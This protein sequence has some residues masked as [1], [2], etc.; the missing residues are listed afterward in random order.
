MFRVFP[1]LLPHSYSVISQVFRVMRAVQG[2][3]HVLGDDPFRFLA[4]LRKRSIAGYPF[5]IA[6]VPTPR[7]SDLSVSH[8]MHCLA[9]AFHCPRRFLSVAR[10]STCSASPRRLDQAPAPRF[11]QA[12]HPVAVV[13]SCVQSMCLLAVVRHVPFAGLSTV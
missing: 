8:S 3:S 6:S 1:G 9:E 10:V 4:T 11:F 7:V 5:V 2:R 12:R 13:W